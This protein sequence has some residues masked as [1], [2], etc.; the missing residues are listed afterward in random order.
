MEIP[1]NLRFLKTH[2]WAR[3][4]GKEV[5]AGVSEYAVEALNRDIVFVE[6]PAVG[7]VV[8][9]GHAF[10]VIE[11]VKA[12]Y[13]LYAPVSGRVTAINEALAADPG[14]V[15][16]LPFSDGWMI[17]IEMTDPA[18]LDNLLTPQQY[19]KQLETEKH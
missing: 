7:A 16:R 5:V 18:E 13:D 4:E 8:K 11:A 17:R 19:G 14:A 10:G 15:G 6:L 9:Q 1:G 12:V 3:V 2:E